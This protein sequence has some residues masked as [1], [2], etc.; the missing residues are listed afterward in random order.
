MEIDVAAIKVPEAGPTG[1]PG[2]YFWCVVAYMD[3]T[4]DPDHGLPA[5]TNCCAIMLQSDD[6]S[7]VD[8]LPELDFGDCGGDMSWAR[9]KPSGLYHLQLSARAL[10][11]HE[12]VVDDQEVSVIKATCLCSTGFPL[13][14]I[15]LKTGFC[16]NPVTGG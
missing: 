11:N 15:D 8:L 14:K 3:Y 2:R 4:N 10:M 16:V 7:M 13:T 5:C 1:R 9:G 6:C 12:G